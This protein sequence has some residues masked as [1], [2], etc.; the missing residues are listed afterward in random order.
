MIRRWL[1]APSAPSDVEETWR[2]TAAADIAQSLAWT[3]AGEGVKTPLGPRTRALVDLFR[4][5]TEG[6]A[7]WPKYSC[8]CDVVGYVLAALGLRDERI[9]NRDDDDLDGVPDDKQQEGR[10]LWDGPGETHWRVTQNIIMLQAGSRA[11]GC[12]VDAKSGDLPELGDCPLVGGEDPIHGGPS[13]VLALVSH[14]LPLPATDPFYR[15]H[16]GCTAAHLGHSIEGGQVD[17]GGQCVVPYVVIF[18]RD[19]SGALWFSREGHP[20][21]RRVQGWVSIA[22]VTLTAPAQLPDTSASLGRAVEDP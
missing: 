1:S 17:A 5:V 16:P 8:C 18:W 10:D 13:H 21:A 6:R 4:R 15:Q 19:S 20:G 14:L 9:V 2:R 11:A 3:G 12:W 7:F 22:K